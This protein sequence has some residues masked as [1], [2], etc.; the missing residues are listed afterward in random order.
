M[1]F[2]RECNLG[3]GKEGFGESSSAQ[4]V[5]LQGEEV[6]WQR[7]ARNWEQGQGPNEGEEVQA[8]RNEVRDALCAGDSFR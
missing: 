3:S 1:A 5:Q 8:R 4:C 6:D 2:G 7:V